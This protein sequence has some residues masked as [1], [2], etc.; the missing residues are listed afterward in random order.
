M[1]KLNIG[2]IESEELISRDASAEVTGGFNF[3]GIGGQDGNQFIG[4]GPGIFSPITAVN[5]P[6]NVP[7]LI[8]LDIDP[9]TSIDLDLDNIIASANT[10]S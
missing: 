5:V 9:V 10:S 2:D 7:V 3:G 6:I 4:A 1:S 8:Q